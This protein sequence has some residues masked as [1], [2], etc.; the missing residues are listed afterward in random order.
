MLDTTEST[1]VPA[2][3]IAIKVGG[4]GEVGYAQE[5]REAPPCAAK[6]HC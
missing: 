3:E 4:L 5:A 1:A 6:P 2:V